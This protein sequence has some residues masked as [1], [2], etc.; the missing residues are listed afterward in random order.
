MAT[1]LGI[2][3]RRSREAELLSMQ[4]FMSLAEL[5]QMMG[6][7]DSTVRRDLEILEEQGLIRRAHGGAVCE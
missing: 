4:G 3:D 6:V 5:V 7:S 2:E 1:D